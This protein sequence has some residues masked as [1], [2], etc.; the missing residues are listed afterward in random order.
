M[1]TGRFVVELTAEEWRTLKLLL[2]DISYNPAAVSTAEQELFSE[3]FV[4][5]LEGKGNAAIR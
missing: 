4:R 3:L 1:G 2:E 5:S